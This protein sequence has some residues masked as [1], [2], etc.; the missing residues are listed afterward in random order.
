MRDQRGLHRV[1]RLRHAEV[2]ERGGRADED[3]AAGVGLRRGTAARPAT[4]RAALITSMSKFACQAASPMPAPPLAFETKT[5]RPPSA[6]RGLGDEGAQRGA[7]ARRPPTSRTPSTPRASRSLRADS[8]PP[9]A[10]AQIATSAPW[11]AKRARDRE[12][13]AAA[14]G[15]DERLLAGES[16]IHV[17]LLRSGSV[18]ARVGGRKRGSGDAAAAAGVAARRAR[19]RS[20]DP[21]E[22]VQ[23][24]VAQ[25]ARDVLAVGAEQ[26]RLAVLL[27]AHEAVVLRARRSRRSSGGAASSRA[28]AARVR[29]RPRGAWSSR[30][31][32]ARRSSRLRP[33]LTPS[34]RSR[35]P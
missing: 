31:A 34:R 20:A 3:D 33:V 30:R 9:A 17:G 14:G 29:A 11:S 6:C 25:L 13:D 15:G 4:P 22:E 24:G 1:V 12:P 23:V 27:D 8:S 28:A 2:L 21:A 35:L 16:E 32:R 18:P 19:A 26:A 5:S 7:V 10:R